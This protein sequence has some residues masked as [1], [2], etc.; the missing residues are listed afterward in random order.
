MEA[1]TQICMSSELA[2][3]SD[4]GFIGGKQALPAMKSM[5]NIWDYQSFLGTVFFQKPILRMSSS[6]TIRE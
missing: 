4:L 1:F 5:M 6:V 2:F 3:S